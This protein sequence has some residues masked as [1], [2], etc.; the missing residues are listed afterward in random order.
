M[1]KKEDR[2]ME[3]GETV[4]NLNVIQNILHEK[5]IRKFDVILTVHRR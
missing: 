3:S 1:C 5:E 2:A 4:N